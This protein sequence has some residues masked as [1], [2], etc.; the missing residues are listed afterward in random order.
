MEIFAAFLVSV[1]VYASPLALGALGGLAS[2][3]SG[4][5]NIALEGKMLTAACCAALAGQATG[6]VF[7]AVLSGVA[8]AVGASLLH[9]W[10][11]QSFGIDHV[12]SG[13]GINAI[14]IGATGYAA[15]AAPILRSDSP[16]PTPE[17]WVWAAGGLFLAVAF[18]VFL[19]TSRGGLRLLAVGSDPDKARTSGLSPEMIRWKALAAAGVFCG[20][21][22]AMIAGTAGSFTKEMSAGRGYIALA[23]LILGGWKPL[24]TLAWCLLFSLFN[25]LQIIFQGQGALGS[26]I[27]SEAFQAMPYVATL[28]ALA[29]VVKSSRAPAGLGKP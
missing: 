24:P 7:L 15:D 16:V 4:V 19:Q 10:L 2:E 21:A 12:I 3:R 18:H 8:G 1:L 17:W 11:T 22:G 13:M 14:A 23:A 28:A 20:L 5:V 25:S 9:A 26:L 27:P 6:S 29:F